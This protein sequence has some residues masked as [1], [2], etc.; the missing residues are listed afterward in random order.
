VYGVYLR[1]KGRPSISLR[2]TAEDWSYVPKQ[3]A[4]KLLRAKCEP[5]SLLTL[6]LGD[7]AYYKPKPRTA[8]LR[9]WVGN[10]AIILPKSLA[11]VLVEKAYATNYGRLLDIL[12]C[13]KW[14]ALKMKACSQRATRLDPDFVLRR[15]FELAE[16][17]SLPQQNL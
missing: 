14:Q 16:S 2:A 12:K 1:K 17:P 3:E 8:I 11:R 15:L 7:G 10:H 13:E 5:L 4:W 6:Y 9:I